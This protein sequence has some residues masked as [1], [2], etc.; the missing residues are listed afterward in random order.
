MQGYSTLVTEYA[1]QSEGAS[2]THVFLQAGVGSLAAAVVAF[3]HGY[4]PSA[5]PTFVVAEPD[6]APCLYE[7]G[8][9]GAAALGRIEGDLPT[10]LAGLACG[11]PSLIAWDIL[12]RAAS[13]ILKCSDRVAMRGMRVLGNPLPGDPPLISGESG[14]VTLGVL[15]ELLSNPAHQAIRD[16]LGLTGSSS[17]LLVST[18]G[19]TNPQL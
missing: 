1:R 18:E 6:G 17:V 11:T 10:I 16:A 7:S 3:M 5:V 12:S 19:A 15:F 13:A 9:P 4:A 14:A 8:R 2:P